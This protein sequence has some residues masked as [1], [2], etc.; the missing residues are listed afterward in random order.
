MDLG[1]GSMGT[2]PGGTITGWG[3][4]CFIQLTTLHQRK[5][6]VSLEHI[7]TYF[8]LAVPHCVCVYF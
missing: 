1:G 8:K 5:R 4:T 3:M 6:K 7:F 2:A